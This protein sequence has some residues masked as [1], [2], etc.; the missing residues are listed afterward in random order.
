MVLGRLP[1]SEPSCHVMLRGTFS[2]YKFVGHKVPKCNFQDIPRAIGTA[3]HSHNLSVACS[4]AGRRRPLLGLAV[5]QRASPVAAA[6]PALTAP[7]RRMLLGVFIL[8]L[9]DIIWVASSELTWYAFRTFEKPFFSTFAKTSMFVVYLLGFLLWKPWRQKCMQGV[10]LAH[11]V[12]FIETDVGC[13]STKSRSEASANSLL[14]EPLYMPVNFND[15]SGEQSSSVEGN[16]TEDPAGDAK[17][18]R[19]RFSKLTEV[20]QLPSRDALAAKLSRMSYWA[21]RDHEAAIRAAGKLPVG[22]VAKISLLLCFVW[23]M[24]NLSFQTALVKTQVAIVNILTSTSGL[25][26]LVLAGVFPSNSGDR[27]TLSKLLAVGLSI[28]GEVLVRVSL[29]TQ[30]GDKQELGFVCSLAGAALYAVYVVILKRRVE[31]EDKVDLPM[32][33]GFLGLFCMLFFWPAFFLLH[34]TGLEPFELPSRTVWLCLLLNG[35]LGTA[36][37]EALW[38]WGCFLTS[39]LMGTLALSLTVPLAVLA[40]ICFRKVQFTWLFF[41]GCTPIFL[42][43][44]AAATLCHYNNWDPATVGLRRIFAFLCRRQRMQRTSDPEQCESLIPLQTVPAPGGSRA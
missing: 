15:S 30:P 19:V 9:V 5:M 25:F 16:D 38:L 6:P 31:R 26:T 21:G 8:L 34:Y 44:A 7:R 43:F 2:A 3:S 12:P 24:A 29:S 32:F 4:R 13:I 36:I 17:R 18:P 35:I 28:G 37:T 1:A 42:A 11:S 40:D 22:Q 33:L 10:C 14:G 27:F 23:F 41:L 20:R 39:S